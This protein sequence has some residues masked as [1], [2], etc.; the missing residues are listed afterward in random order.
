MARADRKLSAGIVVARCIA[1]RYHYLLL[2][3]YRY[4]DFPKGEVAPDESPRQAARRETQEETGLAELQF[5]WGDGYIETPP[6]RG[7]KT[8]RYYLAFSGS[9]EVVLGVSAALGRPEHHECR[10]LDYASAWR[11]LGPRLRAVLEWARQQ[12]GERC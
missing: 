4:W 12:T 9:G 1:G 8:A 3:A 10:W 2:R 6:Y 5:R 11:L 7:N